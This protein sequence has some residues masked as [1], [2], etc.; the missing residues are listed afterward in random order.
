MNY[1]D[2][3]NKFCHNMQAMYFFTDQNILGQFVN[4]AKNCFKFI[5]VSILDLINYANELSS[6]NARVSIER[7]VTVKQHKFLKLSR[8]SKA[9]H[10][11]K[12][13]K[14]DKAI[15]KSFINSPGSQLKFSMFTAASGH[16]LRTRAPSLV[17]HLE[18]PRSQPPIS[19]PAECVACSVG[20][21]RI[22]E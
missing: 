12:Y 2:V 15:K 1:S 19:C 14:S 8:K 9:L 17:P 4:F 6:A 10:G 7:N 22:N 21:M 11:N 5:S 13:K 16:N 3:M 20:G 18:E